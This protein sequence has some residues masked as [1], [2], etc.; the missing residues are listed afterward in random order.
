MRIAHV[1][2]VTP[3]RAGLYETTRDLV[4][5]ERRIGL[6]ARIV[7][8]VN[9]VEMAEDRGVPI[10]ERAFAG[11]CDVIVNHSGLGD[12]LNRTQLPIIH[13]LHGR[14]CSSFLLEQAGK[15]PVYT[16]LRKV[17]KDDRFKAFV[18]F[19]PEFMAYWSAILPE[20]KLRCVTAPV[21]LDLWTPHGP[22]GYQFHG[23]GGLINVVC[24][25]MWREDRTPYHIINAFYLFA[26]GVR[27]AKLHVYAQP[28]GSAWDVLKGQLREAGVL[29]EVAGFVNGLENVYRAADVA[30]TPHR[31]ATRSVREPLACGCNVVMAPGNRYRLHPT[32]FQADPEDLP[33]YAMQIARAVEGKTHNRR[34]AEAFFNPEDT[35]REMLAVI[36]SIP[37]I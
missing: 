6:D 13:V 26:Q 11:E 27:G 17:S 1:A 23:R 34:A 2:V 7:D 30:I 36:E 12:D 35:A 16:Y 24:A 28:Q 21:D 9:D 37:G 22:T 31:I 18:T 8:P 19:W 32:P 10:A 20:A 4:A 14:P 3:H 29:G 15:I 25:S 5:A 33:A